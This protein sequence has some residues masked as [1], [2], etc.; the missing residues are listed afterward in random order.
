MLTLNPIYVIKSLSLIVAGLRHYQ[1][2]ERATDSY[3]ESLEERYGTLDLTGLDVQQPIKL[4]EIFFEQ[5]VREE[6]N[7]KQPELFDPVEEDP[8][9]KQS[10]E[11]RPLTPDRPLEPVTKVLK[12][13]C[14]CAV[15]LGG[16]GSGKS[17]LMQYLALDW[18]GKQ[19]GQSTLV[20]YSPWDWTG[21]HAKQF[22]VLIE[23][24]EY[25]KE[26]MPSESFIEFWYRGLGAVW[27]FDANRLQE[28]FKKE[29]HL[30]MFDGL[31]EISVG[32]SSPLE[33]RQLY[34][35]IVNKIVDFADQYPAAQ[36]IVTSRL[37]GYN[38]ERLRN[39]KFRH[40]TLQDLSRFQIGDFIDKWCK[41]L[42]EIDADR[43]QL[44]ERL[45]RAFEDS[46]AI[47]NLA[48]NPQIL[49]M[50]AIILSHHGSLPSEGELYYLAS[51][52]RLNDS[53]LRERIDAIDRQEKEAILG[54]IACEMQF[55]YFGL[56]GNSIDD[57]SLKDLLTSY[58][59]RKMFR[60][61]RAMALRTIEQLQ[62][63]NFL[64]YVPAISRA[65][66]PDGDTYS[67]VHRK[68]LGYFCA[69]E[70]ARRFKSRQTLTF[71]RLRDT[72]FGQYWR[73]DNRHRSLTLI[74]GL[75]EPEIAGKLIEFLIGQ[76][77]DR[78]DYLDREDR[79]TNEAFKHLQLAGECLAKVR[80]HH[81]VFAIAIRLKQQI[82]YEID[83]PSGILLSFGAA[84]LLMNSIAKYY[85]ILPDTN[86]ITEYY[87]TKSDTLSWFKIRALQDRDKSI[88]MAAI[89]SI[90][91]YY[92]RKPGT[93]TWLKES[94]FVSLYEDVR[95][96][97]VE[98]ITKHYSQTPEILILLKNTI[99][100]DLHELVRRS[101]VESIGKY[102]NTAEDT[103]TWFKEIG[104]ND[105]HELVRRSIVESI[106][107]Y[108]NTAEDTLTW[109]KQIAFTDRHELVRRAAVESIA[110]YHHRAEDILTWLK[111][112]AFGDR[113]EL[114]RYSAVESIA[115]YHHEA[116]DTLNWLKYIAFSDLN[117]L[118]R[119]MVINSIVK[120]CCLDCDLLIQT[121]SRALYDQNES[122]RR[123]AV[124]LL[125]EY[126]DT[127]NWLKDFAF[128]D[129]AERVQRTIVRSISECYHSLPDTWQWLQNTA[130]DPL[131]H[132]NVR[133]ATVWA[134]AQS[135]GHDNERKTTVWLK[136]Y[137]LNDANELVR[138][139]AIQSLSK[140][141]RSSETIKKTSIGFKID[142]SAQAVD[143]TQS[144]RSKSS[145]LSA[146]N[147]GTDT[148]TLLQD[149]ALNDLHQSVRSSVVRSIAKYYQAKPNTSILLQDRALNDVH[150]LVR[151]AAL[152]SLAKYNRT[153]P[154]TLKVLQ[155]RAFNDPHKDVRS[156][157]MESIAKYYPNN[158]NWLQA[159]AFKDPEDSV[160]K[161]VIQAIAE[162]YP[163]T[164]ETLIWLQTYPFNPPAQHLNIRLVAVE[165]IAKYYCTAPN[166]LNWLKH[167]A[168]KNIDKR[169]RQ[170][171]VKSIAKYYRTE[172]STLNWLKHEAFTDADESV[173]RTAIWSIS[174][175]FIRSEGVFELFCQVAGGD[176]IESGSVNLGSRKIALGALNE[177]YT[178][179]SETT[180]LWLRATED[181]DSALR[182]WA[183]KELEKR[184]EP[185]L[186]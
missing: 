99:F 5:N 74:C 42:F 66:N 2:T 50:M 120:Y 9:T 91:E 73:S 119:G 177:H 12:E 88:R 28:S 30:V 133:S 135:L 157:A 83:F 175:Y 80:H 32:V 68:F 93:L 147:S 141:H 45:N 102:Y 59:D 149:R 41:L 84:K 54:L 39:A 174:E 132:P 13:N 136:Q 27:K 67:F 167:E 7:L 125:I 89:Q 1:A 51:R 145:N 166:I 43:Q 121:Q 23:L 180:Q 155:D 72:V 127:L 94:A 29:P 150:Q 18:A 101:A 31:D 184:E 142:S 123:D 124:R 111:Y 82:E 35:D 161:K 126:S 159:N 40:F 60:D 109:L 47:Q 17:T 163:R 183:E 81:S 55:G 165:S 162:C 14:R 112:T 26:R 164:A 22:P 130:F 44:K 92:H 90:V 96:T 36:I 117:E 11:D 25:A 181:P 134:L 158:L 137:A 113:H 104:F 170:A 78:I 70:I 37:G 154:N 69:A 75:V 138:R 63:D 20:Q 56:G 128:K 140:Y 169:V 156:S 129:P 151:R 114:V 3:P 139:A 19:T 98:S 79:A 152:E 6:F 185:S 160:A 46:T 61:P 115:K 95:S 57:E 16:P 71:D 146:S 105:A 103:L 131:K 118:V 86:S 97:I 171:V 62:S 87:R 52:V 33:N 21:E 116:E 144:N 110:K 49:T 64:L 107:K 148:W 122:S 8:R 153:E 172:S 176:S 179:R 77:V 182:K 38:P 85:G 186:I 100:K 4:R 108:Y 10:E 76:K 65:E 24:G 168:F 34:R 53:D 58:L 178:D 48:N 106:G 143:S 173:Q 15:I